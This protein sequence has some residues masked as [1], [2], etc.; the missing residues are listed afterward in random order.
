MLKVEGKVTPYI[1]QR[2]LQDI[3]NK[4]NI[5]DDWKKEVIIKLPKK[6]DLGDCNNLRGITIFSLTSKVFSRIILQRITAAVDDRLRQE[7]AGFRKGKSCVDHIFV[8]RQ[9]L[10]QSSEWNSTLFAVF[11][12]SRRILTAYTVSL[13]G[14]SCV[15][16]ASLRNW[17]T[18]S[19]PL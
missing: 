17:F 15:T 16:T 10:E 2:I 19:S 12:D 11:V 3:W 4:E 8:L 18:S 9:I 1:L 6:G 5:L 14:R 7:Q 13:S